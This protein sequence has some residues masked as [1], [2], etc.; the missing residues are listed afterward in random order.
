MFIIVY[1]FELRTHFITADITADTPDFVKLLYPIC[2]VIKHI[3]SRTQK[4]QNCLVSGRLGD[5]NCLA[6]G[7]Y[8]QLASF[9]V[10]E[11]LAAGSCAKQQLHS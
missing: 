10:C 7:Q 6:C 4:A 11:T 5:R 3:E 1:L 9:A 8:L 2:P